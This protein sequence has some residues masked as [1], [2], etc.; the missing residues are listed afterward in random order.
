MSAR[1]QRGFTLIELLVVIA[2]IGMLAMMLIPAAQMML[3]KARQ[4]NC[5]N[6]MRQLAIAMKSYESKY[7]GYPGYVNY[8]QMKDGSGYQDRV[9]HASRGASWVIELLPELDRRTQYDQLRSPVNT[10]NSDNNKSTAGDKNTADN[11]SPAYSVYVPIPVLLCPSNP[12]ATMVGSPLSYV[13]NTGLPDATT[14][15]A[16]DFRA[17][18][19]FM[20]HWS[21]SPKRNANTPGMPRVSEAYIAAKDGLEFTLLMSENI[22]AG[23]Y[24]DSLEC[25]LGMTWQV[26]TPRVTGGSPPYTA[27]PT[28]DAHRI[29]VGRGDGSNN[30]PSPFHALASTAAVGG[31][32]EGDTAGG[33]SDRSAAAATGA[34]PSAIVA[35]YARPSSNHPG[36]V[37]VVFCDGR[38]TFLS[39]QIDY[40]VYCLM[41]T[42]DGVRAKLP[43]TT[44][45]GNSSGAI[46]GYTNY[47][48]TIDPEWIQR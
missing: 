27:N 15:G 21:D 32:S 33:S 2:I 6:N 42:P 40:Y 35:G 26:N 38:A 28:S 29:N 12:P 1:T 10:S 43:G 8:V 34:S 48:P 20:D 30:F 44:S 22:D 47:S 3:E 36:G 17:N 14:P 13:V 39:D 19:I 25:Y 45:S 37:N 5:M 46:A 31:Q 18:G 9:Y 4:N 7:Q 24:V 16:R 11:V 23:N 41:M